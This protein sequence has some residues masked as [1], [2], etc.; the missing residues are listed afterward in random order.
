[1]AVKVN[2]T[3]VIDNNRN[4]TNANAITASGTV[5]GSVFSGSAA[6]LTGIPSKISTITTVVPT[7]VGSTENGHIWFIY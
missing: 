6:S 4:I 5:S 7:T 3:T 2:N 1:M